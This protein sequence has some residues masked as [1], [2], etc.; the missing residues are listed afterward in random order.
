MLTAKTE[1][2]D[3]PVLFYD[4]YFWN[5]TFR[6]TETLDKTSLQLFSF[7]VNAVHLYKNTSFVYIGVNNIGILV[8]DLNQHKTLMVYDRLK[9]AYP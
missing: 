8:Y 6:L 5:S 1:D 4:L 9:Q 2:H 3:T 7:Q